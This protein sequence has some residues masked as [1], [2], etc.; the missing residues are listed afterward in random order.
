MAQPIG[1]GDGNEI[2]YNL[3]E[4]DIPE[5]Q[6]T[7]WQKVTA[8]AQASKQAAGTS[9]VACGNASHVV[10]REGKDI[11]LPA[12]VAAIRTG[13][14]ACLENA[15]AVIDSRVPAPWNNAA[16][17][18]ATAG[19]T[20]LGTYLENHAEAPVE[21]VCKGVEKSGDASIKIGNHIK[22]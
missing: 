22:S 11:L 5:D 13:T 7:A 18:A 1:A 10:A 8:A 9:S 2:Q 3:L 19:V 6:P 16:K 15:N 14:P 17:A 21:A 12:A 4:Q 20:A